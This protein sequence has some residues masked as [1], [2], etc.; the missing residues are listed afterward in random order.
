MATRQQGT[1]MPSD[2]TS[3]ARALLYGIYGRFETRL[4]LVRVVNSD[5]H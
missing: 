3:L 2:V 5:R 4:G 1:A